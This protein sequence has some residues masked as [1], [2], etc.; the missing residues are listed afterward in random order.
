MGQVQMKKKWILIAACVVV[1][2]LG[3]L[4]IGGD[5]SFGS[6]FASRFGDAM[7][8][9]SRWLAGRHS[10]NCGRIAVHGDPTAATQCALQAQAQGKPFTVV[11]NVMG[12][13]APVAGGIVRTTDG[14]LYALSFDG[15]P[16]GGGGVSLLGQRV[17]KT[18]CPKPIHLWVNPKGRINCFQQQLSPPANIMSPNMESY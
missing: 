2:L 1:I 10:V 4:A 11:Y 6:R 12:Y 14:E 16:S 9:K 15:D 3:L 8:W 13:D 17:N 5:D 7:D 18:P